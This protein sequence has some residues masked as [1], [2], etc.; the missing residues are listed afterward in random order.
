MIVLS[1]II[2]SWNTR[3]Y[4]LPC[5]KS[6]FQAGEE[7]GWEVIVVDNGSKDGSG[8]EAKR[9][10]PKI[11]LIA[12]EKNLGFAKATNQGIKH[13]SG[14]W[15]LLLNPDT[16]VR[17]GAIEMLIAFMDSHPDAGIAGAQLLNGDGSKQNSIANFPS[18]A[19]EL[20][21]KSLLRRFFPEAFP[22]KER[23]YSGPREV[24]SVIGACLI[25]RREA[26]ERAGILD[27]DYFLFFEETDWCYR[28]KKTGW[29]VFHVPQAEVVHF[30]GRGAETRK[31]EAKVEYYRSR[32]RFFRKNRG[33][34]QW[35]LLCIGLVL[36]LGVELLST[37]IGCLA[38]LFLIK[39][40]R[41][42]LSI[43]AYLMA[44]HLR[45]C[46]GGMGL[47]PPNNH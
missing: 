18:L 21:N 11:H 2:V 35:L 16:E 4:L 12:N 36:K 41:R 44:W 29:R 7:G 17:E 6:I 9:L 31:R 23:V 30:Q 32:Y 34:I 20:L 1:V 24:D 25:A 14:K 15:I 28:M 37:G 46:P 10:F 3:Q 43:Y 13:A 40:W 47:K 5:L 42:R 8:K 22:G 45:F 38:T 39:K 19:T 26:I 33:E 27:E